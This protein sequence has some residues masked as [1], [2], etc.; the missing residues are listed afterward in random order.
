MC[1]SEPM[2]QQ[3]GGT[4]TVALK[5][6]ALTAKGTAKVAKSTVVKG[7]VGALDAADKAS[8]LAAKGAAATTGYAVGTI[9]GE[10]VTASG[11]AVKS[12]TGDALS[13]V[14]DVTAGT[15]NAADKVSEG[16]G[17]AGAG[18]VGLAGDATLAVSG[19][20]V[21]AAAGVA[22]GAFARQHLCLL[23]AYKQAAYCGCCNQG[24]PKRQAKVLASWHWASERALARDSSGQARK[25]VRPGWT[26]LAWGRCRWTKTATRSCRRRRRYARS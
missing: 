20:V 1:K 5:G 21:G 22:G 7:T 11:M 12:V 16:V 6:T 8:V 18:V 3:V 17:K 13:A 26:Q 15:L 19:E 10:L 25:L 24:P 23:L 9:G 2:I 4:T 14:T